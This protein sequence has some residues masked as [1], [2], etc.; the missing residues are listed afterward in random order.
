MKQEVKKKLFF[1]FLLA[2]L[3]IIAVVSIISTIK[4]YFKSRKAVLKNDI[5]KTETI[6]LEIRKNELEKEVVRLRTESGIE[7][8]IRKKFNVAK[9]GEEVLV[10]VD[11]ISKGN[12]I[13]S[14]KKKSGTFLNLSGFFREIWNLIK[15]IFSLRD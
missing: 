9:P 4:M 2:A 13:D 10:I 5:V 11:K 15:D 8:E 3:L 12:K 14:D 7:K 1:N 6:E